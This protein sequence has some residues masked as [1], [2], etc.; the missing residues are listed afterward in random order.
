MIGLQYPSK[1]IYFAYSALKSGQADRRTA[2]LDFMDNVL[3]VDLKSIILPLLEEGSTGHLVTG[4]A[5]RF[6]IQ[7]TGVDEAVKLVLEGSDSWLR[8]CALYEVGRRNMTEMIEICRRLASE[9]DALVRETADWAL[10]RLQRGSA[11]A[12]VVS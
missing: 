9:G 3:R 12:V 7:I 11:S 6:G 8:A 10:G 1:D 2:A 5:E 4:A